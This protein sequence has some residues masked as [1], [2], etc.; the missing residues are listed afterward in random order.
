MLS[1]SEISLLKKGSKILFLFF[2]SPLYGKS[3]TEV[4]DGFVCVTITNSG[5]L[6]Y[7]TYSHFPCSLIPANSVLC[8][9]N[10]LLILHWML[11]VTQPSQRALKAVQ[12][13]SAVNQFHFAPQETLHFL[14]SK[15][16]K[17]KAGNQ[18]REYSFCFCF[19]FCSFSWSCL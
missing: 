3:K 11:S 13:V 15:E 17:K 14:F 19:H 1:G 16:K 9:A 2:F 10:V 6:H 18:C 5:F 7:F 4:F 8:S 12:K